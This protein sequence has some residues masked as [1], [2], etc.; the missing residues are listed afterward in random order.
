[1]AK[2]DL[3]QKISK[4]LKEM[5][6]FREVVDDEY[7]K[8]DEIL[9]LSLS[10]YKLVDIIRCLKGEAFDLIFH[11][12]KA[13]QTYNLA[14]LIKKNNTKNLVKKLVLDELKNNTNK[15]QELSKDIK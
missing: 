15:I 6:S 9:V 8:N 1:M 5:P 7:T 4:Q 2:K 10:N 11:D 14:G 13:G 12:M 3:R